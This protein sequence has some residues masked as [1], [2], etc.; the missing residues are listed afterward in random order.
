MNFSFCH[1]KR[2]RDRLTLTKTE[3]EWDN[4]KPPVR[5]GNDNPQLSLVA[6]STTFLLFYHHSSLSLKQLGASL[7][8]S[9]F[10]QQTISKLNII[11]FQHYPTTKALHFTYVRQFQNKFQQF[12]YL[13]HQIFYMT[14]IISIIP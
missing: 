14:H 10:T 12:P 13:N 7:Y 4:G 6:S 5:L 8:V 3:S 1:R 9:E 2:G 11:H